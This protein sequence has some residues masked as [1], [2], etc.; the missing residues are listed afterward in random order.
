MRDLGVMTVREALPLIPGARVVA[1]G[2]GLGRVVR[3]VG[4]MEAPDAFRF[5]KPGDLLLTALYAIREDAAAQIRLVTELGLRSVAALAVKQLYVRQPPAEMLAEADRLDLPII[6]LPDEISYSEVMQPIFAAIVHNQAAVLQ[7]QHEVYRAMIKAVLEQRGLPALAL[8]LAELI[9]NPVAICDVEHRVL[10]WAVPPGSTETPLDE[11]T[12]QALC[13][14]RARPTG[15]LVSTAG[16]LHRRETVAAAGQR[17]SRVVTPVAVGGRVYGEVVVVETARAVGDLDLIALDSAA[18]VI[19]LEFT[20]RRALLEVER[21]YRNEFL[22]ALL[23]GEPGAD[24]ALLQRAR[25]FGLDLGRPHFVLALRAT[26]SPDEVDVRHLLDRVYETVS[27]EA[28]EAGLVGEIDQHTVVVRPLTGRQDARAQALELAERLVARLAALGDRLRV[29]AGAS[30][31]RTGVEG[32]RSSY[33]EARRAAAIAERVWGQGRAVHHDDLGVYQILDAVASAEG[34]DRFLEGIRRLAEYDRARRTELVATLEAF[35]AENG[36][37]R[38]V[39]EALY[40]H[41][42]TVLYRLDRI[43]RITG[44]DLRQADS[45][46]HLQIALKTARLMGMIPAPRP[47]SAG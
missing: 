33:R 17:Q 6:A 11:G 34:I 40:L 37:I 31:A 24:A 43:Q 42:N 30:T 16:A 35:F 21:R 1:G 29:T 46:L 23:S 19:A 25:S 28:G 41:Y 2:G 47:N 36:S 45:R 44:M 15:S 22:A 5:V 7:R 10:A 12:L 13:A 26:P 8:N 32:V 20:N 3:S 14:A 9:G 39:S 18:T 27:A 38:R 4:V